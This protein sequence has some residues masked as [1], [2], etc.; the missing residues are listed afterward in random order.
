MQVVW[1][2]GSN[3]PFGGKLVFNTNQLIDRLMMCGI[4]RTESVQIMNLVDSWIVL[5]GLEWT[6]S[7]LKLI[8]QTV[9]SLYGNNPQ[10]VSPYVRTKNNHLVGPFRAIE[11][12][13]LMKNDKALSALLMYS[14]WISPKLTA[15]QKSKFIKACTAEPYTGEYLPL[16]EVTEGFK[17]PF[18]SS[19][20]LLLYLL[21][22]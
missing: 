12:L 21:V 11:R 6:V 7:H 19:S 9:L 22:V 17:N 8:K 15:S 18:K 2:L 16:K 14:S 4:T 1:L 20:I 3:H 10:G 13:L 5:S